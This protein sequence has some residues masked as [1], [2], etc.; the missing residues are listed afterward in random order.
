LWT[1]PEL[2]RLETLGWEEGW[3]NALQWAGLEVRFS[4]PGA[5]S[6]AGTGVSGVLTMVS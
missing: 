2:G 6:A 3:K 1:L 4:L 5:A